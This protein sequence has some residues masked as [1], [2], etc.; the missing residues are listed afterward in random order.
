MW[1][2]GGS[3]SD[4]DLKVCGTVQGKKM[5]VQANWCDYVFESNYEKMSILEKEIFYTKFKHLPNVDT[6]MEVES[7][8][9]DIAKNMAAILQNVEENTIDITA[10]Y[11]MILQLQKEN[12]ELKKLIFDIKK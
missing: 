2:G 8:G 7:N 1:I 10:L 4:V 3:N 6:Q 9:L 11:K 12:E 5:R